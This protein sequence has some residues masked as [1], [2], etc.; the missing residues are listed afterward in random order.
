MLLRELH[1]LLHFPL[2]LGSSYHHDSTVIHVSLHKRSLSSSHTTYYP[3][4]TYLDIPRHY[5]LSTEL[6]KQSFSHHFQN[7]HPTTVSQQ[8]NSRTTFNNS[9]NKILNNPSTKLSTIPPTKLSTIPRQNF[10]Q[11][12]Q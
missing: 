9:L 6:Q 7:Q 11:F 1:K 3:P 2:L 12:P 10:Q 4:N 5:Y 8:N